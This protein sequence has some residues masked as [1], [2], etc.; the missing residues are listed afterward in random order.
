VNGPIA[1]IVALTCFGNAFLQGQ[2]I[3]GFFPQNSTCQFCEYVHFVSIEKPFFG[4]GKEREIAGTPDEWFT[5][6]KSIA[7]KGIY[8]SIS[9]QNIAW[10]PDRMSAGLVGGGGIWSMEAVI[11]EK[12]SSCWISRWE[13]GNR[14]D[15]NKHIWRV[16]YENVRIKSPAKKAPV[17]LNKIAANL[18]ESLTSIHDF[19]EKHNCGGFTGAFAEALGTLDSRGKNLHGY[20]RDL[21]PQGFLASEALTILDA[22]Q[23]AWV[24]GGMGSWNDLYF[25]GNA[26]KE[27]L[28]LSEDLFQTVKKAI[29]AGANS[30]FRPV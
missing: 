10:L 3:P 11:P 13:V 8:L 12:H 23:R 14:E 15:P 27:Y 25:E 6:L 17:V 18:S 29:A 30:T 28:K 26:Q 20:H 2:N 24:F 19:S 5:Y 4:K 9:P 22:C 16:K 1:Q 21:A 7:A